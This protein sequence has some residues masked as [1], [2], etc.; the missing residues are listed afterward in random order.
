MPKTVFTG[1]HKILV[2]ALIEARKEA[3][4]T[5]A[6]L[7]ERLGKNQKFISL[8]ESAQRRVD[9][10]EFYAIARAI[11]VD[12]TALFSQLANKLPMHVEI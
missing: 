4:L 6:E 12:P 3:G 7:G 1:A 8:I 5:Q 11:G 9:T 10:L 2:E